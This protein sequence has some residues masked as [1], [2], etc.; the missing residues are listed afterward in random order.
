MGAMYGVVGKVGAGKTTFLTALAQKSLQGKSFM[1]LPAYDKVFT[2]FE[3][4]DCYKLDF[5]VLGRYD[6]SNALILIDEIATL[7]D[8]R[9]WKDFAEN[10]VYWF[11][12]FRHYG[13]SVVWCSQYWDADKKIDVRTDQL[14]LMEKS[15]FLPITFI[16]PVVHNF[17]IQR[18]K[19]VDDYILGAPITWKWIFRPKWYKYFD[20]F[21]VKDLPPLPDL[22]KWGE[23]EIILKSYSIDG[24]KT[25]V[26][27]VENSENKVEFVD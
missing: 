25:T 6:I 3:C 13:C 27:T 18:G 19:R 21:A 17:G 22:H 11:S 4:K 10:H 8:N 15:A 20:S 24:R 26:E 5:S 14:F 1:G 16:K 12:H 23:P 9:K 7:A 2:T